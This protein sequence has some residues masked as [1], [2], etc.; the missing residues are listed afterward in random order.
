MLNLGPVPSG[1]PDAAPEHRRDLL[2]QLG[3]LSGSEGLHQGLDFLE[4]PL[5]QEG[6]V[7]TVL[8][9]LEDEGGSALGGLAL[10]MVEPQ[11]PGFLPA[12]DEVKRDLGVVEP[13]EGTREVLAL[14]VR[15]PLLLQ[16]PVMVDKEKGGVVKDRPELP[17]DSRGG[18]GVVG[19]GR[20]NLAEGVH[21]HE[22]RLALGKRVKLLGEPGGGLEDVEPTIEERYLE[23]YSGRK[24]WSEEF[25]SWFD[26]WRWAVDLDVQDGGLGGLH[27]PEVETGGYAQ[28]DGP[29]QGAL[30]QAGTSMEKNDALP[31]NVRF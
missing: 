16:L 19:A 28:P 12:L 23:G 9:K 8:R 26:D 1:T 15:I 3:G 27:P 21:D 11:D 2:V 13:G 4:G 10:G 18:F 29:G 5:L 14:H 24:V 20:E 22:R 17:V 31:G 30:A 7:G 6:Q 25:H